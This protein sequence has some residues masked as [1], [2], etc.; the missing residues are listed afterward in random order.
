MHLF[1]NKM[2]IKTTDAMKNLNGSIIMTRDPLDTALRTEPASKPLV[3]RTFFDLFAECLMIP[4]KTD[5]GPAKAIKYYLGINFA[6][7]DEVELKPEEIVLILNLIE[8]PEWSYSPLVTGQVREY[9]T[10]KPEE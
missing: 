7:L 6:T 2:K 8:D 1:M 10:E 3:P 9:L 5:K 4:I